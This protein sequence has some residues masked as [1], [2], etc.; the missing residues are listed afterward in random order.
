MPSPAVACRCSTT[1]R[2]CRT[3]LRPS[4]CLTLLRRNRPRPV[5]SLGIVGR[6]PR[7]SAGTSPGTWGRIKGDRYAALCSVG[8]GAA[9]RRMG[10]LFAVKEEKHFGSSSVV[11]GPVV[12]GAYATMRR[13][14][15]P[16]VR[17]SGGRNAGSV[18]VR[19]APSGQTRGAVASTGGVVGAVR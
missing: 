4:W 10:F 8:A 14:A 11:I 2:R 7:C 13:S 1:G 17:W 12:D 18:R 5:R 15:G 9:F 3:R 19:K 6:D 16:V